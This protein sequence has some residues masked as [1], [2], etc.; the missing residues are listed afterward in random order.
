M[1]TTIRM[2]SIPFEVPQEHSFEEV[3]TV[4]KI[5]AV[6]GMLMMLSLVALGASTAQGAGL[7]GWN[8]SLEAGISQ[9]KSQGKPLMVVIAR[10]GCSACA[11]MESELAKSTSARALNDVVKVRIEASQDPETT[12][13]FA[14]GGTPTTVIFST[15]NYTSPVYSYTGAMD[16][17]TIRQLG[18]SL[19]GMGRTR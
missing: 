16:G 6:A 18:T 8:S 10:E 3:V 14:A 15:G 9:S 13:R 19:S 1:N 7:R 17:S 2:R 12:S 11:Q 5:V 4:R